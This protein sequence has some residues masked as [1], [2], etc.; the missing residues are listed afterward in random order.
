ME[1]NETM[2]EYFNALKKGFKKIR[3]KRNIRLEPLLIEAGA[4][5]KGDG[6]YM[7]NDWFCYPTKGFAM[8]KFNNNKRTSIT[9]LLNNNNK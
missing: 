6:I 7:L 1:E 3:K 4:I 9:K 2:G 5:K 8:N